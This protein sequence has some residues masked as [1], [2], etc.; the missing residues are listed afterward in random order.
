MQLVDGIAGEAQHGRKQGEGGDE[1]HQDGR[2]APRRQADHVG[3]PDEVEAEQ[4]DHHG[5]A[6]EEDRP[7]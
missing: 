6:G 2:D 5:A 1:H 4:R 3:L 7:A